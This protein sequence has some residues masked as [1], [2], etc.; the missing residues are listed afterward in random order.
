ME[1]AMG[2]AITPG[3]YWLDLDNIILT[4][5]TEDVAELLHPKRH[6]ARLLERLRNPYFRNR[7]SAVWEENYAPPP[8]LPGINDCVGI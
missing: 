1:T 6:G 2:L 3:L 8:P 7:C 5:S 4:A